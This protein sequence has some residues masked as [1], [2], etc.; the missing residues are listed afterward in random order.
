[1]VVALA[2]GAYIAVQLLVPA[3][4]LIQRGGFLIV[5]SDLTRW[6]GSHMLYSWQM[7]SIV[8]APAEYEVRWSDGSVTTVNSVRELGRIRGRAHYADVPERLCARLPEAVVV[9]RQE[10]V[11]RC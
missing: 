9:R 10:V 8:S 11:H 5:G 6:D 1:M 2:L 3:A 4:G 7:F